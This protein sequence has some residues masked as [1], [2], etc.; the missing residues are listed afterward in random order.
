M[1]QE[2]QQIISELNENINQIIESH[3]EQL[4][5]IKTNML[6]TKN[7]KSI[8][9]SENLNGDFYSK[10]DF[11]DYI[12]TGIDNFLKKSMN[13]SSGEKGG[14]FIPREIELRI[15]EQLKFL[16][17]IR[18][19][20][21]TIIIS[22]NALEIL[23][24]STTPDAGWAAS[25]D[26]ERLET[27]SPEVK[28]IKIQAHELY[29]KPKISQKLLDDSQINI[30][31]WLVTKITEKF[32]M[33][34]N[35]S[36]IRGNGIDMPRGFLDYQSENSEKREFGTLRHFSAGA[37]GKFQSDGSAVDL[38]IEIVCSIKPIYV[39]NAKWIM[40]RSAFAE[41]R[42]LTNKNGMSLWQPSLSESTPS[43]LLGYPV[44]IDDSMPA[45]V[46]GTESTSI[47]FGDFYTGYQI[48]DRQGL[49]ILRDPYTSKPFVEF[50]ATKRVGGEV[51]DFEAIK[52]LK[53][54]E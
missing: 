3:E 5:E 36:F 49:E 52:L 7:N 41:I 4:K 20:A 26:D 31:E 8:P 2:S 46:D 43:T 14:H 47:A 35:A 32:A 15:N 50:Y 34:E 38:L 51:V 44:I 39:K 12:R 42:K 25:T 19:I 24:N 29:A 33:L 18:G 9:L 17:P 53:F 40:P 6:N 45:L 30:E 23:L 13:D 21:K 28:K 11:S 27:D 48:V 22:S 37:N 10:Y 54:A 1:N 16:S